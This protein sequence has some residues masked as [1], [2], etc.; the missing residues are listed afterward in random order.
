M[1]E[2]I[3]ARLFSLRDAQ[4]AAFLARL[5][6]S[7]PSGRI[8]GVRTPELKALAKELHKGLADGSFDEDAFFADVPHEYFEENQLHSFLIGVQ[9]DFPRCI[10]EIEHFLPYVDNWATCD[11]LCAG[12]LKRHRTLACFGKDVCRALRNKASDGLVFG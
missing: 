2:M 8:L 3:R 11:Q 12:I 7:V 5:L 4:Y 1:K 9:K 6:P 10:G